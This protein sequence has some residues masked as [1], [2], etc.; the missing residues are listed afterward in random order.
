MTDIAS[1]LA[2]SALVVAPFVILAVLARAH[3]ADSRPSIGDE[4]WHAPT[5]WI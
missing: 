3:G 1:V 2:F 5:S 4:H